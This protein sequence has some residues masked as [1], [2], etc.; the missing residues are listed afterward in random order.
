MKLHDIF[1]KD[2][3][4]PIDG[5]IKADDTTHLG[6]E[7]EEYVLTNEAE[8]ALSNLLEEYTNYTNANGVWISG[9]FGSGKSHL[10]KMLAHL[11]GDVDGQEFPRAEVS[12]SFK[13][14]TTDGFLKASLKKAEGIPARSLLFNIDQ[15]ADAQGG[16]KTDAI[17]R[18]FI[19]VF[20]NSRGYYGMQPH[21][22][23]FER[24]LDTKGVFAAFKETY[25]RIAGIPWT[26]GRELD[27]LEEPN[28][29]AAYAETSGATAGAPENILEKYRDSYRVDI[30]SFASEVVAWLDIQA[31][32][33][34]LNFFVDEV[35]QYIGD[36]GKLMLSLETIAE[37]LNTKAQGRAWVFVTSQEA[38]DKVIGDRT[39]S[40]EYDFSKIQARFKTRVSLSSADV[41]E[42]IRKRLLEKN[43]SGTAMLKE[44]YEKE[45]GSFKT[46]FDF[47]GGRTYPNY[48]DEARFISTYPLVN[49]QFP[50]FAAALVGLSEH[51]A[52][53]GRHASVGERSMLG[54]VQQVAKELDRTEVGQIAA[55]DNLFSGIRDTVQAAAKRSIDVA[56]KNLPDQGSDLTTLAVRVLKA[57]FLVKYVDGFRA[58]ARNLAVLVYDRFGLNPQELTKRVEDALA[59]LESQTYIQRN[60]DLYEYLTNEEQEIEN[61]IKA[62][63]LDGSEVGKRLFEMLQQDVIKTAKYRY[64]T[65][66]GHFLDYSFGYKIDDVGY[67]PQHALTVH[68]FTPGYPHDLQTIRAHSTGL[69]ELR[70]ALD[71]DAAVFGDLRLLLKTER[72]V[73]QKQNGSLS[74]VQ[75]RILGAKAQQNLE[76]KKE[77]LERLRRTIGRATLI[78]YTVDVESSGEVA[79]T[80]VFDGLGVLV[81][82]AYPQLAL[83]GGKVYAEAD[84]QKFV[85]APADGLVSV[86]TALTEAANEV[87]NLGIQQQV[88]IG[89]QITA[90]SLVD[91][92]TGKPYG[93]DQTSTLV[94]VAYLFGGSRITIEHNGNLLKRTEV[95]PL[96]K[97]TQQLANLK[98]GVQKSFDDKK[99]TAFRKFVTDFFDEG[100][101]PKDALELAHFGADKLKDQLDRL[102]ES[103]NAYDYAFIAQLEPPIALLEDVVG[104]T[105]EWYLTEFDKA[106][107]LLEAKASVLDPIRAFL[108]DNRKGIYDGVRTFLRDASDN[109]AYL[110]K[111]A[112]TPVQTLLDDPAVFRGNRMVDLQNE[113]DRLRQQIDAIVKDEQVKAAD[114]IELRRIQL[115]QAE[116]YSEAPEPAQARALERVDRAIQQTWAETSVP[117]LKVIASDFA[118]S[119]FPSLVADL[120]AARPVTFP[121]KPQGGDGGISVEP[122]PTPKPKPVVALTSITISSAKLV[123][124]TA[125]DVDDYVEALRAALQA[126]ISEG[127]RITR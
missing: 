31:P 51:N 69:D 80:R 120:A 114:S 62:V 95:P 97:N 37:A 91:K 6:T 110:S 15:V 88:N 46:V 49:Y 36:D 126:A 115:Q 8:K 68:F 117:K 1:E 43:A 119:T 102:K 75:Q 72:Y 40:Q 63:D 104:K 107:E 93:W 21:V 125:A 22:A 101:V 39:K 96:L 122:I 48:P 53:T 28:V 76:R 81:T 7:V 56:E 70:V 13:S 124:T 20:N 27:V 71:A 18:V 50:L 23:R 10:L 12:E 79:D 17:L 57:L 26:E 9:F 55:F 108:M 109:L 112:S 123:L 73:K 59:L 58:T 67:G 60:G 74:A 52:F 65:P 78:V 25:E 89:Q 92:F 61:E 87:Y 113:A 84:F 41:E 38:M 11:L 77:L 34:R 2:V 90:K 99:V 106:D 54:V 24:D 33:T 4:R 42:V 5:V 86:D 121:G 45:S 32:G 35:G 29:A 47:V 116:E 85:Q 66:K 19:K 83:L 127:K 94:V 105:D 64:K 16:D 30:D 3:T 82:K 100:L 98:I 44:V 103:R 111:G 118:A 14:K